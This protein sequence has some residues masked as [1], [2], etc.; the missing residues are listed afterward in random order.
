VLI[1]AM[2]LASSP[3]SSARKSSPRV[4]RLLPIVARSSTAARMISRSRI[5]RRRGK[6][7]AALLIA[8]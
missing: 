4:N 7:K 5:D 8:E 6:K 1:C 3:D 2:R